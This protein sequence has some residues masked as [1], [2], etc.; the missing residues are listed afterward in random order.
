M[1]IRIV[2]GRRDR[3]GDSG[4]GDDRRTLDRDRLT[5]AATRIAGLETLIV[6]WRED[7]FGSGPDVAVLSWLDVASMVNATGADD[8]AFLRDR[9]GL[10]MTIAD[11]D[12]YELMSRTFGSLPTP[13]SILRIITMAARPSAEADLFERLR[14]IQ[15]RLTGLGLVASQVA[16]R[17]SH[18]GIEAIVVGLWRDEVAVVEATAGQAGRPAF[19]DE[20]EQW[21]ESVAV[22]TYQAVE[23]APRL[24]MASGPPLLLLDDGGRVVDLTPSAAAALGRTQDEAVGLVVAQL[25]DDPDIW[26]DTPGDEVSQD[27]AGRSGSP[28]EFGSVRV[29][30][31]LRR[32]VPVE[33]RHVLLVRREHETEITADDID[34][35]VADAFPM[36][37]DATGTSL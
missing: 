18:H 16:R 6:G 36:T 31:R 27:A 5:R 24:P 14:D 26:G 37:D 3:T 25:M 19:G 4:D 29:H 13:T 15:E 34:A 17:V 20:F 22:S 7:D 8:A 32:D 10:D 23:I 12:S 35:A 21:V 33:H 11:A 2:H 9:L 1:L 30:W 28:L